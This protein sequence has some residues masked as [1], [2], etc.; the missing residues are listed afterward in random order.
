MKAWYEKDVYHSFI[1]DLCQYIKEEGICVK[2]GFG[3]SIEVWYHT[4]SNLP[5]KEMTSQ[6]RELGMGSINKQRGGK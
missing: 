6:N 4:S 3:T 1:H 2:T 5:Y